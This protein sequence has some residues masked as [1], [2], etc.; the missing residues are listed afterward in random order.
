[1]KHKRRSAFFT[2][3][4]SLL[5][6]VAMLTGTTFA[7]F[8]DTVTSSVNR[9]A[10][11]D[12][13]I[14]LEYL[15]D[16]KWKSVQDSTSVFD[17]DA[18][19]EPGHTEVVYLRISNAGQL[20]L[21]YQL[22]VHITKETGSINAKGNPFVLSDYIEFSAIKD[23]KIP[24]ASRE[25]ARKAVTSSTIL[26]AGYDQQDSILP[27]GE[28]HYVA[29]VVYMPERVGNDANHATGVEAPHIELGIHLFAT[30]QTYESDS[31]DNSYDTAVEFPLNNVNVTVA[32]PIHNNAE[33]GVVANTMSV[34]NTGSGITAE[35]PQ[36]VALDAGAKALT[37]SVRSLETS[38][39]NIAL[40]QG[41]S[42]T[43]LDIHIDGVAADNTVPMLI[44]L[45]GYFPTGLNST[46]VALYHVENGVT[47]Q[48]T[49]T[50]NPTNHNEFSYDPATGDVTV[51]MASFSEVVAVA[52][53]S[54]PWNGTA[55]SAF[56]GGTGTEGDPYIIANEDQFA[57]FRNEVDNGRTFK[58][59]FVQ[60]AV[61]LDLNN[62]NFDPIGWGYA[63]SGYNRGGAE[64]KVFMGTF[65]GNNKTIFNLKQ[66]GWD[67]ESA[68]GTDYTYTNCG[69]GLF[70]A[71]ADGT[72]RNL[73]IS[74]ADI[75]A[76]CVEMGVL[77][78]LSQGTC[79]YENIKIF[80]SKIA[81]YQRPTGGLIGEISGDGTTY[82]K[83]VVIRSDVVVGSL[84]GDFDAPVGGVI[85][86]RWD[87]SAEGSPSVRMDTVTVACRLDVYN[88]VT[89]TYQWYA[90]R[91]AGMLIGN[92]DVAEAVDGRT[93]ASTRVNGVDFLTCSEVEIYYGDWVNYHYCEF[94]EEYNSPS[95]PFVR[96]EAGENCNAFSNPR[97][98]VAKDADRNAITNLNHTH[99][100]GDDHNILLAFNQLYGG[101][102]GV[103]GQAKH[104]G[105]AVGAY[106][107]TYIN[108]SEVIS[109]R[110]IKVN[111]SSV[112]R[113]NPD[114]QK[115]A[116][117]W[118]KTHVEG[119]VEF[120][121]WMT[122]GSNK[123]TTIPAGND[124]NVVLY[125]YFEKPYTASFVDQKG[126]VIAWC[127]F[128]GQNKDVEVLK[129]TLEEATKIIGEPG[130]DLALIW[131]VNGSDVNVN[132]IA[133]AINSRN[134]DVTV[135]PVY[136]YTGNLNLVP[137]DE[138]GNGSTDYYK[139]QAVDTLDPVTYIPGDVNG[140]PVKLVEKL[141]KND[142]NWDF[143]SGVVEIHVGEGVEELAH[144]SLS[145]T[146]DLDVVYL[147]STL[148]KLNKNVFSRN[149]GDD[150]KQLRIE[151]NGTGE[152]FKTVMD[153]STDEPGFPIAN[154]W[155]GGLKE[156]STVV[157]LDGTYT[158]TKT[159]SLLR[160]GTW[161]F[162]PKA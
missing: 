29:L 143:G 8:T 99:T 81:N 68:T 67:L 73:T 10:A 43:S 74:G 95:W 59:E 144:N 21:K 141:Y 103:Y 63:Y 52:N 101:G 93:V 107:I 94:N 121:G 14:E 33:N 7:W 60:L 70:A 142:S 98:G 102:Q 46:S 92:T 42:K 116:E 25:D 150:K 5:L 65:D 137:V 128:N 56:N 76:E 45:D 37:L 139:V 138:D 111:T 69:M 58:D 131:Q 85:G 156:G 28:P 49:Q 2:S 32:A 27:G 86:A 119:T 26:S 87:D 154:Y 11:G 123:D 126:N 125:P 16:G 134:E 91:R 158:L 151:Y 106:M 153:N 120:G 72:V 149:T 152:E 82:I 114:A 127:F 35:I 54:D 12:L 48:M 22:G 36:G 122:A 78:G 66:N 17:P 79:T 80:N 133:T 15:S 47:L 159:G 77:V 62:I 130:K 146:K 136:R 71:I 96:V 160:A 112:T 117:A 39:A 53:L 57:Y 89:S 155:Y 55:A 3:L 145:Y 162:T 115:I 124:D 9:I 157:C 34:G 109:E 30:Q 97:W 135:Y 129:N 113:D 88:D 118:V 83:N 44:T 100:E 38:E 64:G 51:A 84:W 75:V 140:I 31:F 90:Y 147:P 41:E 23:V 6:C 110:Y 105:V 61:N 108:D 161:E 148:K 24:Y 13:D 4:V 50:A 132:N 19:W 40:Q 1:M 20:A 104:D 18:L